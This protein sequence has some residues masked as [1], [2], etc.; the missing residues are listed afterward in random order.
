MDQRG[1]LE[2]ASVFVRIPFHIHD[3]FIISLKNFCIVIRKLSSSI[4][5]KNFLSGRAQHVSL[6][7]G[8]SRCCSVI[9]GVRRVLY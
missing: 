2:D 7:G 3:W 4:W 1:K 6:P 9:S 8:K 5:I